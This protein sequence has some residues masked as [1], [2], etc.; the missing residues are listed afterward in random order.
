[1]EPEDAGNKRVVWQSSNTSVA[2]VDSSGVL[3]GVSGGSADNPKKVEVKVIT[4]SGGYTAIA[5]VSVFDAIHAPQGFSPNGDGV[6]DYFELTTDAQDIYNLVVTDKSGQL[7][8]QSSDYRNDWDG[9]ANVG[10]HNGHKLPVGS[11][12]YVISG[13]NGDKK[14]GYVVLKY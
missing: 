7:H 9:T 5:E 8:Y 4:E 12:F 2:T 10:P 6:N 11:Y 14:S 3:T 13:K 1:V